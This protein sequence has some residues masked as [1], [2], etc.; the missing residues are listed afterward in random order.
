MEKAWKMD[1]KE[2]GNGEWN[3]MRLEEGI[4]KDRKGG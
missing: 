2:V 1:R 4:E 3:G